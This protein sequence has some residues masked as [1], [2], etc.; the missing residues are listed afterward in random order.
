MTGIGPKNPGFV[1]LWGSG[2]HLT[3]PGA[4]LFMLHS[5]KAD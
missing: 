5:N 4:A 1:G 3:A 2:G